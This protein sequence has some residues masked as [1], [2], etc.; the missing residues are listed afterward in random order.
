MHCCRGAVDR[1][2]S[3]DTHWAAYA[4]GMWEY[5]LSS[6]VAPVNSAMNVATAEN[7]WQLASLGSCATHR[8][9]ADTSSAACRDS[10]TVFVALGPE[11]GLTGECK[12][13]SVRSSVSPSTSTRFRSPWSS[14]RAEAELVCIADHRLRQ[15][16]TRQDAA[17][18]ART[19]NPNA[20][21]LSGLCECAARVNGQWACQVQNTGQSGKVWGRPTGG[22]HID[23]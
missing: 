23:A 19:S 7:R 21:A 17:A 18:R 16:T 13:G 8:V 1:S 10:A 15:V 11:C 14:M 9:N 4:S 3:L 5:S 12:F 2:A 6:Q 22:G 20:S